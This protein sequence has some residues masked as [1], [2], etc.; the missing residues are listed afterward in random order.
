MAAVPA[1]TSGL[2]AGQCLALPAGSQW[3]LQ[4]WPQAR[5]SLLMA[6][7]QAVSRGLGEVSFSARPWAPLSL[8][9][10]RLWS[11][12]PPRAAAC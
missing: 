4:A 3:V 7:P 5:L 8:R 1:Q 6:A 9:W 10:Q 2:G 11:S 12:L